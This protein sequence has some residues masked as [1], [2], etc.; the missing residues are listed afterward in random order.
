[1][2]GSWALA[3]ALGHVRNAVVEFVSA[4][5]CS[6]ESLFLA[7]ECLDLEGLFAELGVEP[8]FVD[9]GP[10]AIESLEAASDVLDAARPVVP[11]AV[12]AGLQA[13]RA[14]AGR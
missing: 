10:D 2:D 12:W 11:L 8:E 7:A 14:M 9:P 4:D 3:V 13:V 1:V 5:D 6:G